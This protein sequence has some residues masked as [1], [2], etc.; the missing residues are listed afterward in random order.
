MRYE[1]GKRTVFGAQCCA[2]SPFTCAI[3][4]FCN[5]LSA[6]VL[7]LTMDRAHTCTRSPDPYLNFLHRQGQARF[8]AVKLE[9]L[10]TTCAR[11]KATNC[12]RL[13]HNTV[14]INVLYLICCYI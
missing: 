4:S 2:R 3:L 9:I 7:L 8:N 6:V 13:L 1:I 5:V 11:W 12:S 10:W 14:L